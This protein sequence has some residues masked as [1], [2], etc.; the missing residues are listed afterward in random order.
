MKYKYYCCVDFDSYVIKFLESRK[1]KHET[2]SIPN[3][4]YFTVYSDTEQ[5]EELLSYIKKL[6][7][8][9]ITKS[10]VYSKQEMEEANWYLLEV[11]RMGIDTSKPDFTYDAQCRYVTAYGMKKC[12]HLEQVREFISKRTPKWK[13]GYQFCSVETGAVTIIFC[14]DYA[15]EAIIQSGVTGVDFMNVLKGDLK[16]QTP[17][18]SQLVFKNKLPLEAYKFVGDYT[19]EKCP[20]CGKINYCFTDPNCDNIRLNTDLIP[21]GIDA[22]GS[23]IRLG[24][25]HGHEPIVISKK[26]YD[27]ITKELKEK[28]KHFVCHPIG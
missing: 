4:L 24:W 9:S 28:T 10:S 13:S 18:V 11:Y 23:Q 2:S 6:E 19:E 22:F 25:G 14:S 16:T 12:H 5:N 20:M 7:G 26:L 27:L 1:I 21:K 8:T 17:D 15:K 3:R